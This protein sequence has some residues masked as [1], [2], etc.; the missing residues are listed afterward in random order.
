MRV[1]DDDGNIGDCANLAAIA[2]L[3]H[4]RRPDVTVVGDRV[5][6]HS[7]EKRQPVQMAFH[8]IPIMTTLA[9]FD[10]ND[11]LAALDPTRKESA[12]ATAELTYTVNKHK[13]I[14]GIHKVGGTPL[15]PAQITKY[16]NAAITNAQ[17]LTEQLL[18]KLEK[19][20]KE[21]QQRAR[22]GESVYTNPIEV[23]VDN[24]EKVQ[25]M[26]EDDEGKV[27]ETVSEKK[28]E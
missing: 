15:S 28:T 17:N 13:E 10:D 27:G 19:E 7:V 6:I 25:G 18:Q 3:M 23:F 14:C 21:Q 20:E 4:F 8:H 26:E 2:S 24:V 12:I 5:T 9:F 22:R 16:A 1:L 11:E